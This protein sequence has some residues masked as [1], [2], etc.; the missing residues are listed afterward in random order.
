VTTTDR[1]CRY[2]TIEEALTA[3]ARN[4]QQSGAIP[5]NKVRIEFDGYQPM[6]G[7]LTPAPA[8]WRGGVAM[9]SKPDGVWRD[10]A[11]IHRIV[12]IEHAIKHLRESSWPFYVAGGQP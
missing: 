2:D 11:P 9:V 5:L 7:Y 8:P 4:Y 1:R 12:R 10:L 3:L 6:T